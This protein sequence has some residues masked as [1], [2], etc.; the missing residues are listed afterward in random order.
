MGWIEA[1]PM[2]CDMVETQTTRAGNESIDLAGA[3]Q[4]THPGRII[5]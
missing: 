3:V 1:I 2:K 4:K 5:G